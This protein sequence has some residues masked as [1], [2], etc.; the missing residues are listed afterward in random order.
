MHLAM[1]RRISRLTWAAM[2]PLSFLWF[3]GGPELEGEP[4]SWGWLIAT[5]S[6]I[7]NSRWAADKI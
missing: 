6:L 7:V 4:E 3:G 2:A 1:Q 5:L